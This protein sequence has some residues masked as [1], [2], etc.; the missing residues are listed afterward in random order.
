[1]IR[2][3][4]F[5]TTGCHLCEQAQ[6]IIN[7]CLPNYPELKIETIDIAEHE[8][9]QEQYAIRIPVLY[10]PETKKDLGWPFIPW[11]VNQ[12]INEITNG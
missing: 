10:H 12:F 8:H 11:Q 1:M 2:L 9:W 5:G 3:L 6:Q 4:F 7:D